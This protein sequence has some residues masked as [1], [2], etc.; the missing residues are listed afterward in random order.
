MNR[1]KKTRNFKLNKAS[2]FNFHSFRLKTMIN[3]LII[4]SLSIKKLKKKKT[5]THSGQTKQIPL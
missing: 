4:L 3:S 2:F 1:T 5:L